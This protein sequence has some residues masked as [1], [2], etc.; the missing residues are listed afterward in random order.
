MS[1]HRT[2]ARRRLDAWREQ[3][4]D[5]F[6]PVRFHRMEALERRAASH[7]GEVRDWL[8]AR[9]ATLLAGY[10]ELVE[11][12]AAQQP[13]A[14]GAG[15]DRPIANLVDGFANRNGKL[16]DLA[17]LPLLGDFRQLWSRLRTQ[18]QLRQSLQPAPSNAGPLNSSALAHRAIALMRELSPG[19]LQHFLGYVDALSWMEQIRAGAS[20]S[21]EMA[22]VTPGR[23]RGRAK[24]EKTP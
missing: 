21:K 2:P 13:V 18:S 20:A 19:Y 14:A 6:D 10:A 5:R 7:D 22:Q 12:R 24:K 16:A 8:D 15:E 17:E 23:K 4:A 3:G 9:L 11:C 1:D